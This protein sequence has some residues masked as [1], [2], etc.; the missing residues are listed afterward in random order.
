M[1]EDSQPQGLNQIPVPRDQ[2]SPTM[3]GQ[4]DVHVPVGD[5][6]TAETPAE[7]VTNGGPN[8]DKIEEPSVQDESIPLD[9][10]TAEDVAYASY[11]YRARAAEDRQLGK[12]VI[13]SDE[14]LERLRDERD[15]LRPSAI[16]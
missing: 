15:R 7:T 8:T 12:E 9:Y 4:P 10:H 3:D 16:H 6:A 11:K 1:G 14:T 5:V 13:D 2:L